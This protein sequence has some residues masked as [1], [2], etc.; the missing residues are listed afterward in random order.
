M[1]E[2]TAA[3][4]TCVAVAFSLCLLDRWDLRRRRHELAWGVALLLFAGGAAFLLAGAAVGWTGWTFRGFYL[5][6]AV[7]NVPVLALGTVYLHAGPRRGDRWAL[8]VS[9]LLAAA[10]GVVVAAPIDGP[11]DRELLPQGS[12]VFGPLPRILAAAASAGGAVVVFGGAALS[13]VRAVRG[14]APARIAAGNGLLAAGTVVLSASGLLNSALGEMEAF[15]VTLLAG[16]CLLFAGFLVTTGGA[17]RARLRA[18][19]T[20]RAERPGDSLRTG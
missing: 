16:V 9:M 13:A 10:A 11:L 3:G 17:G 15:A 7:L 1:I 12:D 2:A 8:G 6:G 19:P 4:A 14:A 5:F 18:V 20:V